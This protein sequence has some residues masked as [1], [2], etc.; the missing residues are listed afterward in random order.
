MNIFG[1]PNAA[2]LNQDELNLGLL[3]QRLGLEWVRSHIDS[4]GGDVSR[5]TLWGQSAGAVSVD[6]YNFAYPEDPIVSSLIMD[7]GT[8]LLPLSTVGINDITHSN[9]T[10]VAGQLGCG[11][12][13]PDAEISCMRNVSETSIEGFLET[14]GD[15]GTQP[16]ISFI[17][18]IDNRTRFANYTARALAKDFAH[19]V[20]RANTLPIIILTRK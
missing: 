10:F 11:N 5:I 18:I 14:Y 6:Y 19:I 1:F 15:N 12:L 13:S 2:G 20:C 9:F 8:A 4:F 3:D 17:P 7:S 16:P